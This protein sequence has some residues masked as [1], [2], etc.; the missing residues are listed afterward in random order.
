MTMKRYTVRDI[1]LEKHVDGGTIL[2]AVTDDIAWTPEML[3]EY[4]GKSLT[5]EVRE[6]RAKR[7]LD[8]NAYCW[9]LCGKISSHRDI[10]LSKDGVYQQAIKDYGVTATMPVRDDLLEDVLRWHD[11]GGLGNAHRI[12]GKCRNFEGYTNVCFYY[13]SSGYDS[14]QMSRFIDGI[15]ADAKDLGIETLSPR[16]IERMKGEWT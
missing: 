1:R 10:Y 7:S 15:V 9:V 5:I 2:R 13:G 6:N 16:E 11:S 4:D 8:A 3:H 12:I 14:K